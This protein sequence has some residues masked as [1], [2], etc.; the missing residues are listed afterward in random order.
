AGRDA[1]LPAAIPGWTAAD[2]LELDA[3]AVDRAWHALAARHGIGGT[4]RQLR[5][6]GARPRAVIVEPGREVIIIVPARLATPAD[7]F[8]VLHELGHA[9][10]GLGAPAG[11]PRVLD[12]AVAAYSA[13]AIE[14]P[15][16][17]WYSPLAVAARQRRRALAAALDRQERALPGFAAPGDARPPWAL[18]HD[19]GAQAAYVAAEHLADAL[20]GALTDDPSE[21][22]GGL[23]AAIARHRAAIDRADLGC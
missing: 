9:L 23:I 20:A 3:A 7:R 21:A 6:D 2:G 8:A 17:A 22:P 4:L 19:A 1:A 12:E 11:I 15:G 16:S 18:W 13:R 10:A 5:G 14:A